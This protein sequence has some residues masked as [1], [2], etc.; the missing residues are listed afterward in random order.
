MQ[1]VLS[2]FIFLRVDAILIGC[3]SER[4]IEREIKSE[5]ARE[6]ARKTDRIAAWNEKHQKPNRMHSINVDSQ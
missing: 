4:E 2:E 6:L 3:V 1:K 5:S